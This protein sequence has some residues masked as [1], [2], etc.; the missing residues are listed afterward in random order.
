M[1]SSRSPEHS[2]PKK[3]TPKKSGAGLILGLSLGGGILLLAL[4]IA[5]CGVILMGSTL[6]LAQPE[7]PALPSWEEST[8]PADDGQQEETE[9]QAGCAVSGGTYCLT[10][11]EYVDA[12]EEV[13]SRFYAVEVDFRE[14][15]GRCYRLFLDGEETQLLLLFYQGDW[16]V[17]GIE[18]FHTVEVV[19]DDEM[20]VNSVGCYTC[21]SVFYLADST[22]DSHLTA[23][24]FMVDW[25]ESWQEDP[26]YNSDSIGFLGQRTQDGIA[27]EA[28]CNSQGRP[29]SLRFID[30]TD[31]GY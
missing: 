7:V 16:Q 11:E 12:L 26:F 29:H 19:S 14:D 23:L 18:S 8:P 2:A 31:S 1:K 13:L 27:V 28:Y 6:P 24:Q 21:A 15:A 5:L 20:A 9:V 3:S 25:V 30:R 22:M 10:C 17:G 4:R